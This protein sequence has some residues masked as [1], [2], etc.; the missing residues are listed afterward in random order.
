[1][2]VSISLLML[3]LPVSISTFALL[4]SWVFLCPLCLSR[5]VVL[6]ESFLCSD[7]HDVSHLT[8]FTLASL[9]FSKAS[10]ILSAFIC[11]SIS[12][13]NTNTRKTISQRVEL[14][15]QVVGHFTED[16]VTGITTDYLNP[17]LSSSSAPAAA[18]RDLNHMTSETTACH[19][20][21]TTTWKHVGNRKPRL[22]SSRDFYLFIFAGTVRPWSAGCFQLA[23]CLLLCCWICIHVST[24]CQFSH[25]ILE[26]WFGWHCKVWK[27]F[28][29]FFLLGVSIRSLDLCLCISAYV[30]LWRTF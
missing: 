10:L 5:L 1:M 15:A 7:L 19:S 6:A 14:E 27:G 2:A 12:S 21:Q 18:A 17:P 25:F 9:S 4:A 11:A 8:F 30:L 16:S 20:E 23:V 28:S 22:C 13:C 24:W 3:F 29:T 26:K